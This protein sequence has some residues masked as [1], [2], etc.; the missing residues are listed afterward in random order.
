LQQIDSFPSV[1]DCSRKALLLQNASVLHRFEHF[2]GV[3]MHVELR[4]L[5]AAYR[6]DMSKGGGK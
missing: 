4:E 3:R 1:F 5:V 6:P 2:G